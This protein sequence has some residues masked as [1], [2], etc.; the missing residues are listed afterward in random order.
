MYFLAFLKLIFI[1]TFIEMI[2]Q[3]KYSLMGD[4]ASM[5]LTTY[6]F[7]SNKFLLQIKIFLFIHNMTLKWKINENIFSP[8]FPV[9]FNYIYKAFL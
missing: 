8:R 1:C 2:L 9:N 6:I 3:F 5:N 7:W 4:L